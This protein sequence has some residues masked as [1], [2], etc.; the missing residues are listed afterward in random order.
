MLLLVSKTAANPLRLLS[1]LCCAPLALCLHGGL[2][3][4]R[5]PNDR[6]GTGSVLW[7]TRAA[8]LVTGFAVVLLCMQYAAYPDVCCACSML[9]AV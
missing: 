7:R 4:H 2:L 9:Y 1:V 8:R 5:I 3:L 6:L